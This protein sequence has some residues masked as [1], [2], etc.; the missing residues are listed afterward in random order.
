MPG[1][2]EYPIGRWMFFC[3]GKHLVTTTDFTV[4]YKYDPDGTIRVN[5]LSGYIGTG[6]TL[7]Q[8]IYRM[9]CKMYR[10]GVEWFAEVDEYYSRKEVYRDNSALGEPV[11]KDT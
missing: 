4:A 5:N 2:R 10:A 8:A 9:L 6:R 3:D 7:Q 1:A 11:E